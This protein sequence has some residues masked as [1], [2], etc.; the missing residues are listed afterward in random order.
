MNF[1]LNLFEQ[2]VEYNFIKF[3]LSVSCLSVLIASQNFKRLTY[4][5]LNTFNYFISADYFVYCICISCHFFYR[6]PFNS[7]SLWQDINFFEINELKCDQTRE[8]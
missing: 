5:E 2:K 8:I 4:C 6:I 7:L 1:L 3:A